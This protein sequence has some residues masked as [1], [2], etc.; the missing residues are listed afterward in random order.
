MLENIWNAITRLPVDRLGR[1]FT[2]RIPSVSRHARQNW[3]AMETAVA[4]QRRSGHS[5][6]MGVWR[7]NALTNFDK[8]WYTTANSD[9]NDS[10]VIK[11]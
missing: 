3:V 9:N 2:G 10:H 11:Y 4:S 1:N 6:V 8:I 7:L 5:V